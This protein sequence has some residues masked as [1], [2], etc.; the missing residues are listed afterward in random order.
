MLKDIYFYN[1]DELSKKI[2]EGAI[3]QILV[4]KHFIAFNILFYSGFTIPITIT[5]EGTT[6]SA[7]L[8]VILMFVTQAIIHYYGIWYTYQINQKGDGVNY[9]SRLFCLALPISIRLFVYA[10]IIALIGSF[11]LFV[12]FSNDISPSGAATDTLYILLSGVY[13]AA[14][15]YLIGKYIRVCC[16]G[17]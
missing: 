16:S 3:D 9:L 5:N 10:I 8:L 4:L 14:F 2:R 15:Y 1:V 17:S 13:S 11:I 7:W 12:M 6:R